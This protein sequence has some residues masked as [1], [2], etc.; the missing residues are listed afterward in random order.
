MHKCVRCGASYQDDDSS[1]LRGC[2]KCGSIF[3]LFLRDQQDVAQA[4]EIEKELEAK[5]T[6]LEKEIAKKI[7]EKK[8][9]LEVAVEK[10]EKKAKKER[11]I[12]F[13]IETVRIPREG[14][15][16]INLDAL[17]QK[18]PLIILEKGKVYFIHLPSV[19][20]SK[21]E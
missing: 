3:F 16:E 10:S 20:E 8:E 4:R 17:M 2:T 15:Y 14:V 11:K 6:T 9:E 21:E 12:E 5:D 7:E 13:G 19:F 18:K 1:I